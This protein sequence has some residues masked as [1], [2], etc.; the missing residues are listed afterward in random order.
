MN[1]NEHKYNANKCHTTYLLYENE[2]KIKYLLF[3]EIN[4]RMVKLR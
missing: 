2:I 4:E 3:K 1:E